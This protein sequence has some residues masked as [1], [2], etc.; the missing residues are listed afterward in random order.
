MIEANRPTQVYYET[1]ANA[2]SDPLVFAKEILAGTYDS[3]IKEW[4]PHS[5]MV[6]MKEALDKKW[7][8]YGMTYDEIKEV[9]GGGHEYTLSGRLDHVSYGDSHYGTTT[10]MLYFVRGRLDHVNSF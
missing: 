7:V 4:Y 10:Y 8:H 6:P 2:Q 3:K 1:F 5:R 9:C